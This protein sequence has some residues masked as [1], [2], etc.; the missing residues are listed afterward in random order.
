MKR[1]KYGLGIK[2]QNCLINDD[3]FH[4]LAMWVCVYIYIYIYIYIYT[5]STLAIIHIQLMD[6]KCNIIDNI[7]NL[8]SNIFLI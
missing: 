4:N 8:S 7:L 6:R 3:F 2:R 1:Y 5:L